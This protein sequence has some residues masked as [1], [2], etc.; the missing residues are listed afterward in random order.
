MIVALL[1]VVAVAVLLWPASPPPANP[2]A[3]PDSAKPAPAVPRLTSYM[4]SVAALQT[5]RSRLAAT[6][7]LDA[8]T[9]KALDSLTLALSAGSEK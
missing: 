9:Q 2:F 1:V 7:K 6:E 8:D 4:D 5:V 3:R